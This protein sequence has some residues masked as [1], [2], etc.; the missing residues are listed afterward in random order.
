MD[1]DNIYVMSLCTLQIRMLKQGRVRNGSALFISACYFR[2]SSTVA[3]AL[4]DDAAAIDFS[5]TSLNTLLAQQMIDLKNFRY[6][7]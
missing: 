3:F 7:R 6:V 5:A 2:K 1:A 4:T